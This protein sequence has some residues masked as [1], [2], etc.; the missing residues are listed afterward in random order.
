L[1]IA[2]DDLRD[3]DRQ[4]ADRSRSDRIHAPPAI[5]LET[6]SGEALDHVLEV[7][8]PRLSLTE[9]AWLGLHLCSALG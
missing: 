6:L 8:S 3:R 2:T 5:V 7:R 9:A 1:L 4:I